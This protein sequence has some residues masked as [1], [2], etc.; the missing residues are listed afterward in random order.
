M[1][2]LARDGY[3]ALFNLN[4]DD[5]NYIERRIRELK[6]KKSVSKAKGSQD[7][8]AIGIH[9]RRGDLHPLEYQ[10]RHSY[11]PTNI[12]TDKARELLEDRY[13]RTGPHGG[14]DKVAKEHSFV[15]L[16]SDD[17]MVYQ[18]N[19]FA[20]AM[21]A[22]ERIKLASKGASQEPNPDRSVMRKFID[23]SFGWEGGF[24]ARMFWNLGTPSNTA[25]SSHT[26]H[27]RSTPSAETT[28]LRSLVGRAYMMDLAVLAGASDAVICTV[29]AMGCR[30]LAVMMG[31]ESA[32][33]KGNWVN[34]DGWYEWTG[35]D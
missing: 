21:R 16:S 19:E 12:Y 13:N 4:A 17:P 20:T 8:M 35:L 27:A 6:S 24:Y 14:E 3:D 11:I 32:S 5:D 26:P 7:G 23:E 2:H 30:I 28:R 18:S 31:W 9:V 29:S 10:Y 22:Q 34:I 1:F 33:E 25:S 15:V